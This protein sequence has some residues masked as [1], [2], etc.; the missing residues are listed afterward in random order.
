TFMQATPATWRLLLQAGWQGDSGLRAACTGE[1][2]PRDLADQLLPRTGRLWNMYGPTETTIWST[3]YE[4]KS[5]DR[6][7]IGRP[8]A[9][10]TLYILDAHL[11]PVPVGVVGELYIGG[12]GLAQG[13]W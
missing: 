3:A 4:V 7:L 11:Q 9:N 10:T 13:Y 2:M 6:I 5:S 12:A 1:A 8:A